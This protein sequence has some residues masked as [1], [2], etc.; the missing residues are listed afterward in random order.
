MT[1]KNIIQERTESWRVRSNEA[2]SSGRAGYKKNSSTY[3]PVL[4][5]EL[6]DNTYMQVSSHIPNTLD[7]AQRKH[8]VRAKWASDALYVQALWEEIEVTVFR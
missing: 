7:F 5:F 3:F 8:N 4:F 1:L 6:F 2:E